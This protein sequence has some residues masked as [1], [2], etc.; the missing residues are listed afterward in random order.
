[1]VTIGEDKAAQIDDKYKKLVSEI[2]E[3]MIKKEVPKDNVQ[4]FLEDDVPDFFRY[5]E[6]EKGTNKTCHALD[7]CYLDKTLNFVKEIAEEIGGYS[8]ISIFGNAPLV[9]SEFDGHLKK[10]KQCI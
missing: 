4:R 7:E 1:M 5:W 9:L 3:I 6:L 10:S 8:A 2:T